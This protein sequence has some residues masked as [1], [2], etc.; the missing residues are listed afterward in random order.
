MKYECE[1]CFRVSRSVF[2]FEFLVNISVLSFLVLTN[3]VYVK[4]Y[5]VSKH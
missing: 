5:F 4:T 2:V 3:L 1:N